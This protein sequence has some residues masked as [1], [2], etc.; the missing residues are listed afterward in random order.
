MLKK[1]ILLGLSLGFL[2]TYLWVGVNLVA[3]PTQQNIWR[4]KLRLPLFDE[5]NLPAY[6]LVRLAM[7]TSGRYVLS[8]T[9]WHSPYGEVFIHEAPVSLTITCTSCVLQFYG[10]SKQPLRFENLNF[11]VQS[12]DDQLSGS[13]KIKQGN[14]Q[15]ELFF[16]GWLDHEGIDLKWSMPET[17][18][19]TLISLLKAHSAVLQKAKITG[20]IALTGD[21]QWPSRRW[22]II[23]D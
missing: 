13:V 19:S 2:A 9:K 21:L 4:I 20:G 22:S 23:P 6:P 18:I 15:V 17:R 11:K 5:V 8:N 12:N 7:S 1:Y 10:I 3:S 14:E 16:T